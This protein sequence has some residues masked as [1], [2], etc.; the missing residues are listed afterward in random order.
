MQIGEEK[1][2]A[3]KILFVQLFFFLRNKINELTAKS[4][5]GPLV[6]LKVA[7]MKEPKHREVNEQY[8]N[9]KC[10]IVI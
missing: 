4:G 5:N 2:E 7:N 10:I 6:L 9:K 3:R 8:L 1:I